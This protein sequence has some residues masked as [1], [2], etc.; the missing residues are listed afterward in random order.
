MK[1]HALDN[2]WLFAKNLSQKRSSLV[3]SASIQAERN[4]KAKKNLVGQTKLFKL[5]EERL[6][7]PL[8][9]YLVS[10]SLEESKPKIGNNQHSI[11]TPITDEA[12]QKTYQEENI[13]ANS[14]TDLNNIS[15]SMDS[16]IDRYFYAEKLFD[17]V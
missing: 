12:E 2:Q 16:G 8:S 17:A 14:F 9:S 7:S 10:R 15:N 1:L 5:A 11:N 6:Q 3:I 13:L 4:E